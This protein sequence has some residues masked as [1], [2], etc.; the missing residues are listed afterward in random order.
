MRVVFLAP[1]FPP[2][3]I[4]YTRGLAVVGAEVYGVADTP[5][6]A[7]SPMLKQCLHDYLQVPRILDEDDVLARVTHWLRGK[8]V[9]RVLSNWEPLTILAARFREKYGMP[10]M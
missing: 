7:L 8:T 4:Q 3:M 6:E 5:R 1:T 2:E 10:G 9:D